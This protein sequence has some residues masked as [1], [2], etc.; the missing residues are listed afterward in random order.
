MHLSLP[1]LALLR[2]YVIDHLSVKDILNPT[3]ENV[4]TDEHYVVIFDH[5]VFALDNS[6][7]LCCLFIVVCIFLTV[8]NAI[9]LSLLEAKWCIVD[10][11]VM[12]NIELLF[13]YVI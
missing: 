11:C 4:F 9:C 1:W 8:K 13:L 2:F 10:I 3:D 7:G 5:A 6:E 12:L